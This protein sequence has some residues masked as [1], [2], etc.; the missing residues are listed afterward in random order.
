M[1]LARLL[2]ANRAEVAIRIARAAAG[3]GIPTVGVFSEDDAASLHVRH[4]DAARLL[5]GRG[6]RAYL[7]VEQL[8]AVARETGCDAVHPGYGFLSER[9]DFAQ[10]CAEAGL[11]FVGPRPETLALLGDKVAARALAER[12]GVRVLGGAGGRAGLAEARAFLAALGKS[13]AALGKAVAGGG[14]RGMRVVRR[15]EELNEAWGRCRSE[16]QA[17]F[18]SGDLYVEALLPRA[19][20]V[21]VQVVG[22]GSGAV[23]QLGE[24]DCTLQRR[25]QKLVEVAPAPGLTG[26]LRARLAGAA[27][28]MAAE[29][30]YA[31]V[32]T[33]EFLLDA[34]EP[35]RL[36]FIEANPR[37]QV[38]HTVTEEVTGIDLVVTQL[39]LAA[40][41]SLADLGLR[42]EEI[43]APHG[44]ALQVRVNMETL[45]ADGTLRPSAGALSA[46]EVPTGPGIRV[47]THGYAGYQ[48]SP[49]FD[50]LLA[51]VVARGTDFPAVVGKAYRALAEFRVAGVATN[52]PF[53]RGLLRHPAL[54][55]YRVTTQF[56]D[57][58]LAEL[59]AAGDA[60]H[61]PPAAALAGAKVDPRDPLAVLVHGKTAGAAPPATAA[62]GEPAAPEGAVV[63]RAPMQGTVVA[64]DVS[65]SDAVPAGGQLLVMEAMKMEHVVTAPVGGIVRAVHVS[66][67]DTVY[68]G[69]ALL[70][71][72]ES[73]VE[74]AAAEQAGQTDLAHVRP[75]LAEVQRRHALTLDA[76]RPDAVERRR[77]TGQRTARENI[78]DLRDPGSFV[79][80]GPLVR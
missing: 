52:L 13:E 49:S 26:E 67:G 77:A 18:G 4:V 15:P 51:K 29:V 64:V 37:L 66:A 75:D 16:A 40:G 47:D 53:L 42:E 61:R 46:F 11:T 28:R 5:S 35:S 76:A 72:E 80:Y 33:F 60:G 45:A 6:P 23:S 57:E 30:R 17:A 68:E 56:V 78:D 39:A 73:A 70:V 69:H 32:G 1:S 7:D 25:H 38:E 58:H 8:L 36:A 44:C 21:E 50:S 62:A 65:P 34:D 74:P 10:R 14:G 27:V 19:R 63:V 41:R 54:A 55:A 20:H 31:G 71:L 43:A 3:L 12:C 48:P 59:L 79:E 2:V 24:R 9:A 22:D